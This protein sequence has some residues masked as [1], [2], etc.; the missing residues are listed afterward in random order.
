VEKRPAA[1]DSAEAGVCVQQIGAK[2][3]SCGRAPGNGEVMTNLLTHSKSSGPV[4]APKKAHLGRGLNKST[5]K[6][7]F[8]VFLLVCMAGS[9]N[10]SSIG[11]A[12]LFLPIFFLGKNALKPIAVIAVFLASKSLYSAVSAAPEGYESYEFSYYWLIRE[13]YT[14]LCFIIWFYAGAELFD[15]AFFRSFGWAINL[16]IVISISIFRVFYAGTPFLAGVDSLQILAYAIPFFII[17]DRAYSRLSAIMAAFLSILLL[18]IPDSSFSVLITAVIVSA[19]IFRSINIDRISIPWRGPLAACIVFLTFASL[20]ASAVH[21]RGERK[22]GEGNNGA[23]REL[24]AH[25]AIDVFKNNA[26]TGTNLGRGIVPP[27]VIDLRLD[28]QQYFTGDDPLSNIYA[29]SFH[30]GFLYLL[31][32]FGVFSSV[33]I[34]LLLS[35]TPRRGELSLVL[36]S[37]TLCLAISAN[38]VLE[39]IRAGPGVALVLGI[40]FSAAKVSGQWSRRIDRRLYGTARPESEPS[41]AA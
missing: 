20:F 8:F 34:W 33:I 27:A 38:V 4:S 35:S 41:G 1:A 16:F 10:Y 25:E 21:L 26:L 12:L 28:W 29:L 2:N 24:L 6:L 14:L 39:S 19:C 22:N 37:F 31:T 36:F 13:N 30:N 7:F 17:L 3:S 23:T 40:I 32:R 5:L 15:F 9:I 18:G 11:A